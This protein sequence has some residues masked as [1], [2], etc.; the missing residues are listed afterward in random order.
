MPPVSKVELCA[1]IRR[2]ARAGMAGRAMERKYGVGRRT[3]IKALA[4]A[5]PEP[6]KKPPRRP[7]KLDPSASAPA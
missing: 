2:D 6:R 4:S 5:W 7:S 1:A 3:I